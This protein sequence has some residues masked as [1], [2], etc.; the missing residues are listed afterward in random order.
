M[1][2]PVCKTKVNELD[3]VCPNCK[4]NFDDYEEHYKKH[5]REEKRT[6]ANCLN[7]LAVINLIISIL[8]TITI[9]VTFFSYRTVDKYGKITLETNWRRDCRRICSIDIRIHI[10]FL[11]KNNGRYL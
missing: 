5:E 6:N 4:T 2:C 8:G 7:V 10:V 1:K 3:E 11:I 9:W